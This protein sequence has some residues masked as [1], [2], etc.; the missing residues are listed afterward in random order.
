[1]VQL[2]VWGSGILHHRTCSDQLWAPYNL[3]IQTLKLWDWWYKDRY[4]WNK[5][6]LFS[7]R[8]I[9]LDCGTLYIFPKFLRTVIKGVQTNCI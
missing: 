2:V 6:I 9:S 5:I 8:I 4:A 3:H 7:F 1:V